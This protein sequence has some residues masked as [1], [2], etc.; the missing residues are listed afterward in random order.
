MGI[1]TKPVLCPR[2]LAL[3]CKTKNTLIFHQCG[4]VQRLIVNSYCGYL[5]QLMWRPHLCARSPILCNEIILIQTQ[6]SELMRFPSRQGQFGAIETFH[7]VLTVSYYV[8]QEVGRA[9]YFPGMGLGSSHGL[10]KQGW[11]LNKGD[12]RIF[13]CWDSN[14]IQFQG[15]LSEL[16]ESVP[17]HLFL[18]REK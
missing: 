2:S 9:M 11:F 14:Q 10:I 8:A 6:S 13:E 15:S 7:L 18:W 1:R 16:R 3:V 12:G 17:Y 5:L 4:W